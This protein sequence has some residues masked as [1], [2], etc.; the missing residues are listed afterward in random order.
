MGRRRLDGL[1]DYRGSA[2]RG[3]QGRIARQEVL[4]RQRVRPEPQSIDDIRGRV[5]SR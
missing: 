3:C 2:V 1:R 4:G 5:P